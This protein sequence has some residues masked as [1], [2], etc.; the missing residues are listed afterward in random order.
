MLQQAMEYFILFSWNRK[1]KIDFRKLP[2][3][4]GLPRNGALQ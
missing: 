2:Q 4:I 3:A 1:S